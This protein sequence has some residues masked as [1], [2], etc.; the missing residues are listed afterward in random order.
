MES[1]VAG[2]LLSEE[3]TFE[4]RTEWRKDVS[5]VVIWGQRSR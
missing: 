4:Q 1:V 3:V 5:H 2:T